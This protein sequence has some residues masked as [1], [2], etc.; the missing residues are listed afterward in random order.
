MSFKFVIIL[1]DEELNS[2]EYCVFVWVGSLVGWIK[3]EYLAKIILLLKIY[4]NMTIDQCLIDLVYTFSP[5]NKN[6]ILST[7]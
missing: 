7:S 2:V 3:W 5:S 6:L 4:N 1:Y